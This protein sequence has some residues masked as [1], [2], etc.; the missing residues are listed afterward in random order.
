MNPFPL[1]GAVVVFGIV[2]WAL[3]RVLKRTTGKDLSG[4]LDNV[5]TLVVDNTKKVVETE[6][7]KDDNVIDITA[8]E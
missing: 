1:I 5:L 8:V 3:N 7:A 6:P 4:N 2:D